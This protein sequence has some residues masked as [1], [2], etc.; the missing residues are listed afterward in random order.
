[1]DLGYRTAQLSLLKQPRSDNCLGFL[2]RGWPP[3]R[4]SSSPSKATTQTPNVLLIAHSICCEATC[5][6]RRFHFL[7]WTTSTWHAG[8]AA[9]SLASGGRKLYP[10]SQLRWNVWTRHSFGRDARSIPISRSRLLNLGNEIV[11]AAIFELL[12]N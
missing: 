2:E 5:V 10:S 6:T 9:H 1:M 12:E 3:R 7:P 4:A 11:R 8:G